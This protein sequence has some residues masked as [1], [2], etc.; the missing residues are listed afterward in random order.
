MKLELLLDGLPISAKGGNLAVEVEGVAY[1]SRRVKPG[2]LFVAI[3]GSRDDGHR[4]IP[5]ALA[6][7]ARA[8]LL[9]EPP[10]EGGQVPWA[11]VPDTREALASIACRF[12]GDPSREVR[13]AGITGT[14]GKTTTAYLLEA[15]L[16]EAGREVGVIGTVNYR[17]CGRELRADNTTPGPY[18]LQQLL[19]EMRSSG[20]TDVVM[21]VSSHALQQGRVKGCHFDV[22]VFTNL[23]RDHLDYHGTIEAYLEAKALL[24]RRFLRESCKETWAIYNRE[25]SRVKG[26]IEGIKGLRRL[27]YGLKEGDVRALYWRASLEGTEVLLLTPK[28]EIEV[29][30]SLVGPHNVF[31]IMASVATALAMGVPLEA[32]AEGVAKVERVPGRM[33]KVWGGPLVFV[34]YA[35][36]PDALQKALEGLRSL[37]KGRLIVV[38]G[39]GGERD[40]GKRP[41]MGEVASHLADLV[42]LTSDNPRGEDPLRIIEEI[43]SGLLPGRAYKVILDRREAIRWALGEASPE[44]GVLIAGKGHETYQ[45]IGTLRHPFDDREEALRALRELKGWD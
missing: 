32:I 45:I 5:E 26:V 34:D 21:E 15:I 1:D 27:S 36:T 6:K 7:G 39:C 35:H 40:R 2:D 16:K 19:R 44:D 18:E 33:E 14:N 13:L 11:T 3:R 28:G 37:V 9:Q 43:R 4:H 8:L 42:V 22:G 17:Y 10:A 25:D 20:V 12:F 41:L 38:F 23:G 30:C 29:S 31:N 24:F